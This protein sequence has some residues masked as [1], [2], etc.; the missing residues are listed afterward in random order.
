[1]LQPRKRGPFIYQTLKNRAIHMLSYAHTKNTKCEISEQSLHINFML[2]N[3]DHKASPLH[4][5]KYYLHIKS[6]DTINDQL[7]PVAQSVARQI[8]N[9]TVKTKFSFCREFELQ[10][11]YITFMEID[12]EI[13]NSAI[14]FL[15]VIR[16]GLLIT[17]RLYT[18]RT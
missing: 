7:D 6:C 9:L 14:S 4:T 16:V 11:D 5:K 15:L 12:H 17:D 13:T 1:M 18:R 3:F 2:P 10:T 8:C